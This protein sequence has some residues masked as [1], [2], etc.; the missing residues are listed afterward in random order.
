MNYPDLHNKAFLVTG[1]T[2]GIG[3]G[4]ASV[5]LNNGCIVGIHGR[6]EDVV[7]DTCTRLAT[8]PGRVI[9]LSGDLCD[10]TVATQLATDFI[11]QAERIDGIVNNAGGGRAVAFRGIKPEGWRE[12]FRLNVDAAMMLCQAVYTPLRR[13]GGSIVNIASLAAHGPG[14]WM[15][16]DYAA[17]KAALV[18][19]TRSLAFEAARFNV[20]V[21]A[22]S[23]GM[24]E[25]DMTA[26][27]TETM[28]SDLAIPLGHL[29]SPE[30]IGNAT[31]F[32]L[33]H[34]SSYIT[35]QVLHVDGGLW[36]GNS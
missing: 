20:R 35:G 8:R 36:S 26:S 34:A 15:G 33:S 28:R 18:S 11:N 27:L 2:R 31:A 1:S 23:P 4:I 14:K 6:R 22:I 10:P 24:I 12:T 17:S 19:L 7:R 30:D 3:F 5:L 32:L 16:A 21:N 29:G 9:P 25:T 13:C